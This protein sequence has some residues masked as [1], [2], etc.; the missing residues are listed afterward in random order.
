MTRGPPSF[1]L[2]PRQ[3]FRKMQDFSPQTPG[4]FLLHDKLEWE[5]FPFSRKNQVTRRDAEKLVKK[6]NLIRYIDC[7]ATTQDNLKEVFYQAIMN[8][9]KGEA[10][11][12]CFCCLL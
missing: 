1:L 5:D 6:F 9:V 8:A 2:E 3:I 10:K 11:K 4:P 7:S 12:S